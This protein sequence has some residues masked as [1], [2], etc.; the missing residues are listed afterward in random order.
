MVV[1]H[2]NFK[3]D[4]KGAQIFVKG[5]NLAKPEEKISEAKVEQAEEEKN[6]LKVR[7]ISI[8]S[9]E[10]T[11]SLAKSSPLLNSKKI[12]VNINTAGVISINVPT[13]NSNRLMI[14]RMTIGLLDNPRSAALI[15]CGIFSNANTYDMAIDVPMS[16]NTTAVV[17]PACRKILGSSLNFTSR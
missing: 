5:S 12:G 13:N 9:E 1:P 3:K 16:I 6:Q 15:D 7:D 4:F 10:A 14:N 2:Q 11:E 17:M 8:A